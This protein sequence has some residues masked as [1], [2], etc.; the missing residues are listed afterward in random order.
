MAQLRDSVTSELIAD[1]TPEEVVLIA[2]ELEEGSYLFDDVGLAFNPE[3][4]LEARQG[5]LDE[6]QTTLENPK[7]SDEARQSAEDHL[8]R[9]IDA[10]PDADVIRET[11]SNLD[12]ARSRMEDDA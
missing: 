1:G 9:E 5:R 2:Q 8:S 6:L 3:A 11:Q 12:E 10:I 4:V 7:A